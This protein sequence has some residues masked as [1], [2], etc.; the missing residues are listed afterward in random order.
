MTSR[1]RE[2]EA[3]KINSPAQM[4]SRLSTR[5]RAALLAV[6]EDGS[7]AIP[8]AESVTLTEWWLIRATRSGPALTV[9]GAQVQ[10]HGRQQ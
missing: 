7:V 3:A 2:R 10:Q 9:W 1:T 5:Q 6:T 4:W 8:N